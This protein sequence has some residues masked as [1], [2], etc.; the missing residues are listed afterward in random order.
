LATKDE[1]KIRNNATTG[2]MVEKDYRK[3][4]VFKKSGFDFCSGG[5]K[6]FT[7]K[8]LT[9]I[10]LFSAIISYPFNV[11]AQQDGE[12][13]FKSVCAVCHT[14]NGGRLIGPDLA[15]VHQ[16]RNEEWILKFISSSQT[17]VK[18]GDAEAVAI[19]NEYNQVQ[20]P[21]APYSEAEIKV[22]LDFI[23]S[24][25]PAIAETNTTE[26]SAEDKNTATA[27]VEIGRSVDDATAEE[28]NLGRDLYTGK[29]RLSSG[30]ASCISCHNVTN[31]KIIGGGLLA[32]D[33]T[34]VFTR[35]N[36]A[37]IKAI[38][39]NPPFPVMKEAY[40]GG[41]VTDDEAYLI[42]AFLK[43]A[44]QEQYYQ[45]PRN[46]QHRFLATGIGGLF[47]LLMIFSFIWWRRRQRAVGHDIFKRQLPSET[48]Q[49]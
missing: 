1:R 6:I 25:S 32:K 21:D 5:M 30:S 14:I 31:D 45:H 4:D 10:L 26:P 11:E 49:F 37:G 23:I 18:N 44:D 2:E 3:A 41:V 7:I 8:K 17:M 36:E 39:S 9:P 33:L 40:R 12:P 20:M 34:S 47:G 28:I 15:N 24:Q 42:T 38:V 19:F 48:S 29:T 13:L 22:I 35:M 16:R 46:Y 43:Y 27:D